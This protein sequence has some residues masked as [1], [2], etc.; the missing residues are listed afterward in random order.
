MIDFAYLRDQQTRDPRIDL[1]V[2]KT[3]GK[4][5][6]DLLND[7]LSMVTGGEA[8]DEHLARICPATNV[9]RNTPPTFVWCAAD[10][11]TAPAA[12]VY[13]FARRMAEEGVVHELHVF[14]EGAHGLSV[15][16]RNTE[17]ENVE[18]QQA[19]HA[20]VDLAFDFL[21]RQGIC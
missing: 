21:A 2:P 3:G 4:T 18:R 20:W 14:S 11:K 16:N 1:R 17:S 7:F 19:V 12:Q 5:G 10:D 8:T 9:S 13:P 15:A 6:R